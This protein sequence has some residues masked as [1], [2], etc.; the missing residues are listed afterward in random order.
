VKRELVEGDAADAAASL[1]KKL[2]RRLEEEREK[3]RE[4]K[5]NAVPTS[6][7]PAASITVAGS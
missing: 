7:M 2:S 3:E 6:A 4:Q 1:L 5:D